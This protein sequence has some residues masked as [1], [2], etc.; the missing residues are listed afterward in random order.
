MNLS[1]T[2]HQRNFYVDMEPLALGARVDVDAET[3]VWDLQRTASGRLQSPD[4]AP[5]GGGPSE[6]EEGGDDDAPLMPSGG[7]PAEPEGPSDRDLYEDLALDVDPA[8]VD[9]F[10]ENMRGAEGRAAAAAAS[11]PR[12]LGTGGASSVRGLTEAGSVSSRKSKG[13]TQLVVCAAAA[14]A[15]VQL[16]QRVAL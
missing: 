16:L 6:E 12:G 7:G 15:A 13:G 1:I 9:E 4:R 8:L 11:P 3:Y 5:G 10:L 14:A 2:N